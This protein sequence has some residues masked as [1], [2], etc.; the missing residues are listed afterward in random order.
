MGKEIHKVQVSSGDVDSAI[1]RAR[2]FEAQ[3]PRV[4]RAR[5]ELEEDLV[6]LYFDDGLKV[7]IPRKQLQGLERANPSQLSKIE[8]VGRGTGLHWPLL[9]VDHY[10]LGLL[11]HRFGTKRWMEE[12]GRRGGQ[13]KSKAKTKASRRNGLKGGRPR[14]VAIQNANR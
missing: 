11:E 6:S 8:I 9:D 13:A 1:T 3:D 5:Y 7:S 12:I 14:L 10:V 2:Q 4:I